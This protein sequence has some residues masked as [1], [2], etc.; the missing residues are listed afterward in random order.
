MM[1]NINPLPH[2]EKNLRINVKNETFNLT[3]EIILF[4]FSSSSQL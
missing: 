1:G 2:T 4:Y 3:Q